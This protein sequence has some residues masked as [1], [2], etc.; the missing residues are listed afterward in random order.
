MPPMSSVLDLSALE[1]ES[2]SGETFPVD[3][4]S[5]GETIVEVPRMGA[6]ETRRAIEEAHDA[7]SAVALE[8]RQGAG[9]DPSTLVRSDSR[10]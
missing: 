6:A 8:A 9:H 2:D 4:P 10:S 3:D 1:A 7:L 5:S